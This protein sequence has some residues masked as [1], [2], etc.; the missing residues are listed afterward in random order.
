[1]IR[2]NRQDKSRKLRD[3]TLVRQGFGRFAG[4][5]RG[6]EGDAILFVYPSGVKYRVPLSYVLNWF[7]NSAESDGQQAVDDEVISVVRTRT[8]V[9]GHLAR[10]YLSDGRR[11]DVAWDTVLMACEPLYEHFG[12]LTEQSRELAHRW[13]NPNAPFRVA[14]E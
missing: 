2:R 3:R 14:S 9:D 11:M 5:S 12:G 7:D 4:T 13:Y 1:M 8:L 10:I 6:A